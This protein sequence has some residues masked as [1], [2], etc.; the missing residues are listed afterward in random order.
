[1]KGDS[2]EIIRQLK[3]E[4]ISLRAVKDKS[5]QRF[6]AVAESATDAIIGCARHGTVISFWNKAAKDMFGYA[7]DEIVGK[8]LSSIMSERYF[9]AHKKAVAEVAATGKTNAV[10]KIFELTGKK[11]SGEEFP[12]ELSYGSWS[13]GNE[14]FFTAFIRDITERKK[15]EEIVTYKAYH[16]PLTDLPNRT[17]FNEFLTSELA[18]AK[19]YGHHFA[20]LFLDLDFFK[21]VNDLL[22]H[23]AGDELLQQ[24]AEVLKRS[25]RE[26]ETISRMGGDEFLVLVRDITGKPDISRIAERVLE[27]IGKPWDIEN[28][29]IDITASIG[30]AVFPEDGVDPDSLI[31]NADTAMYIAKAKGRNRLQI[32]GDVTE[33][34]KRALTTRRGA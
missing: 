33:S 28:H 27:T 23:T 4:I 15:L 13:M 30:A 9:E 5:E 17:L 26:S 3:S 16:D 25:M 2:E 8:A 29:K 12:I 19:R 7:A 31:K 21:E 6:R 20:V 22:G 34:E 14:L 24:I 10:G 32:Y 18:R 1:M 11:K